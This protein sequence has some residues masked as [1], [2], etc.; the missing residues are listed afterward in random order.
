MNGEHRELFNSRKEYMPSN[1]KH[2]VFLFC[3]HKTRTIEVKFSI[4]KLFCSFSVRVK[5][6]EEK[7]ENLILIKIPF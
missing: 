2:F 3:N 7:H 6:L 4:L 5:V 1:N